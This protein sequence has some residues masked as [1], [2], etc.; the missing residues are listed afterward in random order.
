MKKFYIINEA[1]GERNAVYFE[2][3]HSE[4]SERIGAEYIAETSGNPFTSEGSEITLEELKAQASTAIEEASAAAVDYIRDLCE[5][6]G[7]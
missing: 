5:A 4:F 6:W 2:F 7:I 1:T 3:E